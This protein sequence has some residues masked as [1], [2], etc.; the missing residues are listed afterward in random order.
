MITLGLVALAALVLLLAVTV[1]RLR[2][3]SIKGALLG[4]LP[5]DGPKTIDLV[6]RV[7]VRRH[8]K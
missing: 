8:A 4:R 5:D 3:R 1:R 6:G 2:K 7:G